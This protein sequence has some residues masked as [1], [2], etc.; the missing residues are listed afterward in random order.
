MTSYTPAKKNTA[1][2]TYICLSDL[3]NPGKFKAAPTLAAGDFKVSIDD[4]ALNNLAT[5]PSVSPAGSIWVKISLSAAEMNG[6]NIKLQAIDAAGSEWADFALTIP[7][8]STQFDD[9][10]NFDPAADTV[11]HVTLVDTTTTNTDMRGTDGANTVTPPTVAQM[12]ARTLVA[13]DYA[14]TANQ[15]A[16]EA[17]TA[18]I[19]TRLPAALVGGLMSS[20]VTAISTSTEA[21][22]NLE[23]SAETIVVG[24]ASAGTLSTTQMTTTLTEATNDH[25][26]GRVIIWTSGVLQD[27]AT[28]ITD[29]DGPSKMLTYTA[30]TEAPTAGDTF[31]IV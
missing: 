15:T 7:T 16:I 12:N 31:V 11:A 1:F 9:L 27:Q 17:D 13:A 6:D 8:V 29:Y 26:N 28:D 5:L 22:D 20:N 2:V 30:V 23:A 14:T 18:D 10:N 19:Q 24:A 21:A 25:Y 3:A 4:G